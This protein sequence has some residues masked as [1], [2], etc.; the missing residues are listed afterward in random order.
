MLL[1]QLRLHNPEIFMKTT[2][3]I[4]LTSAIVAASQQGIAQKPVNIIYV[5]PDQ[6]RNC[7][8]QFW[9]DPDF[10]K[11]VKFR[12]DPVKTP[13]LNSFARQSIVFTQA[14]SNCPLSSPHRGMLFTGMYPDGSGVA[15]N[16]NSDRP[17]SSLRANAEC[18]SDVLSKSG[19]N[20]AYFGKLHLDYPTKNNPQKQ[21]TYVLD[22]NPVWDA[23]TPVERRHGFDYW[24]SY[25]TFDEHKR[26][27]YW[28]TKGERHEIREWSPTHEADMVISY[29]KNEG[30]VRNANKPFFITWSMNPP[31]SPYHSLDDCEE[32]DFNLYKN[33]TAAQ[34][35]VRP[36][37]DT[38]LKKAIN[39]RYYFASVTGVDRAFGR[40]LKALQELGLDK[41]TIVVFSSDHGETFC[42]QGVEDAKN[43][44][45]VEALNVP[46]LVRYPGKIKPRVDNLLLSTPDI[47]PTLLGLAGL[48]KKIPAAVQGHNFAPLLLN[49]ASTLPR[50]T[51][52][53][54]IQNLDGEKNTEGKVISYFAGA[55]GIKTHDYTMVFYI[56]RKTKKLKSS[57]LYNDAKDPY[58][59]KNIPLA[60]EPEVVKLLCRQLA[61][62][63]K[64]AND[65]WAREHILSEMIPYQNN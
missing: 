29:L 15:L 25:G 34:L 9:G 14:Q 21:G 50:P 41:N 52:A 48:G 4:I 33:M 37:A 62:L 3:S 16:C 57:I 35:L 24:Y 27:H 19:Y 61:A 42:S 1:L 6:F 43:S 47:M 13:N 56:N 63:L 32:Q 28:D 49:P 12:P 26:P 64:E 20:C 31:H 18:L 10:A 7:A 58:Q 5:F 45:Y 17:V 23:Y 11:S 40:M 59:L 60:R 46:F 8:M 53:L 54:Y 51:G 55:R 44:P 39:A 38:T 36:N 65:P 30:K 2:K 22:E